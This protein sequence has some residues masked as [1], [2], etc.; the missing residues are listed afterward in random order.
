MKKLIVISG[1]FVALS[2]LFV[3]CSGG[4]SSTSSNSGGSGIAEINSLKDIPDNLLNPKEY[5]LTTKSAASAMVVTNKGI[6]A[7][8]TGG[9][10]R[11]GCE[12]NRMKKNIIRNA[13][14]PEMIL[15]YMKGFEEAS[16]AKATGEGVFNYWRGDEVMKEHT[17]GGPS[18]VEQ[19]LPRMAIKKDG[20]TLTF[21]MC[22]STQKTMELVI[23]TAANKYSGHVIDMWGESRRGKMAFNTDGPPTSFTTASF[24]QSFIENS[25]MWSG[26]GSETLEATPTYNTIYGF[27]HESGSM[28]FAGSAYAMFDADEGTAKYRADEGYY[29][30]PTVSEAY[31]R[32]KQWNGE[33]G[34][35]VLETD[36]LGVNGWL[37][38]A[39]PQGCGLGVTAESSICFQKDSCPVGANAEGNCEIEH[40]ETHTES[41]AINNTD[42]YNLIFTVASTSAY[43]ADVEAAT[44]PNSGT[45]P[46]ID[47]TDASAD[48]DCSQS[49]SWTPL[50][51]VTMPHVADCQAMEQELNKWDNGEMCEQMES[52][53]ASA[54]LAVR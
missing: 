26:F 4:G 32:C 13:V 25:E 36:W 34:C 9:F 54:D 52:E 35:G 20:D 29:P 5:D 2:A 37:N 19:F 33:E 24:T 30:A 12:T 16:G 1:L 17:E 27:H 3:G 10:S 7:E 15:C 40:G 8:V 22:N 6:K 47:F 46:A 53:S 45:E 28:H 49:D 31:E 21:V 38:A 44:M 18:E 11:A 42:P 39:A 51:F 50:T 48:V 43:A 23:S 14:M 41:F